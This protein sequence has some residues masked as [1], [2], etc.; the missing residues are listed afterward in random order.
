MDFRHF[1][2]NCIL[3]QIQFASE[4]KSIMLNSDIFLYIFFTDKEMLLAWPQLLKT[5][6]DMHK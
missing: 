4:D 6:G 5:V 2:P 3:Q 1:H